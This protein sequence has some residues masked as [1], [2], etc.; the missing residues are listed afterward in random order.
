MTASHFRPRSASELV[1]AAIQLARENYK[2]LLVLSARTADTFLYTQKEILHRRGIIPSARLRAPSERIDADLA[3]E[4]DVLLS[5]FGFADLGR[6][7]D[8]A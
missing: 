4:L 3:R 1:D 7:W 5:E 6:T 2:P 8:P